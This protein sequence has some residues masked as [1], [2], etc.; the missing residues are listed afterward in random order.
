[1]DL[2][3]RITTALTSAIWMLLMQLAVGRDEHHMWSHLCVSGW[4]VGHHNLSTVT[5]V[6]VSHMRLWH[7]N[8]CRAFK[9]IF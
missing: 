8:K 7:K 5:I 3:L 2:N 1:M 9:T 4:S 6:H